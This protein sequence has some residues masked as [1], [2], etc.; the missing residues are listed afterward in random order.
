MLTGSVAALVADLAKDDALVD[1]VVASAREQFPEVARLPWAESRRHVAALLDAGF[2]AFARASAEGDLASDLDFSE[3]RRFGAE[4]AALGVPVAG[5]M[6]GVHGGRSRLLEIAINRGREA[7]IPYDEL[8][9]ALLK[10]DRYGTELERHVIDGY[11][12]AEQAL[13]R[14]DRTARIRVLRRL[15]LD[16]DGPPGPDEDPPRFGLHV[17][18]AYH[19][20][21]SDVS[22]PNRVRALEQAFAHCGGVLAPVGGRLSGLS[23]RLPAGRALDPAV[24]VVTTPPVSLDQARAAYRLC[25]TAL[26][27][28]RVSESTGLCDV[29]DLA[30]E[31]A[32]AGQP[33]LASFLSDGLLSALQP[34][35]DFHRELVATALAFLDHG[36]R[37]DR[38]AAALHLHPNTVR[39]R[40][41]RLQDLTGFG[42]GGEGLPVLETVRWWWALHAWSRHPADSAAST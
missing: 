23:P 5:L 26:Q 27:A 33:L 4:R 31:T 6:A 37:L 10:L 38:T 28:A 16:D 41:R 34:G 21:I 3:A 18:T 40:L 24:L 35:D 29:V 11:R 17:D 13:N 19:C 14:D 12:Q 20:V 9:Q 39:Y 22:D 7:G 15:L 30:G 25:R 32:L 2:T 42:T 8:L 36:Q 1:D